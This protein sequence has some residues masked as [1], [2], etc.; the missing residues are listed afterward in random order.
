MKKTWAVVDA[1]SHQ[2][3]DVK[4]ETVYCQNDDD[5]TEVQKEDT[6]Q[7]D[8]G[9]LQTLFMFCI[10]YWSQFCVMSGHTLMSLIVNE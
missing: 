1:E 5:E 10:N 8:H 3:D 4:R 7:G 9:I 2:K 6:I